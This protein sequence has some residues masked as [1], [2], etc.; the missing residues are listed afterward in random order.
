M[1]EK[2][3]GIARTI[4]MRLAD[5][6]V[7]AT[8]AL[9]GLTYQSGQPG[10][11]RA[12]LQVTGSAGVA[13]VRKAL[14]SGEGEPPLRGVRA[15]EVKLFLPDGAPL[16]LSGGG[17]APG[18][19][20]AQAQAPAAGGGEGEGAGGPRLLDLHE[21][22]GIH[23]LLNGS[24]RK[25]VPETVAAKLY[26]PAGAI[27]IEMA[28]LA[29]RLGLETTGI[30]LPIALPATGA[31]PVEIATP[32]AI[33]GENALTQQAKDE[34]GAPGG[35]AMDKLVAGQFGK[36]GA[37]ELPLLK[38]G[39]GEL[40]VVDR[41]FGV[42]PALLVR[43]D[44]EGAAAAM[45]YASGNLPYLWE[46]SKK[47]ESLE[48]MRLDLAQFFSLRSSTGQATAALFDLDEWMNKIVSG[49]KKV[50]SVEAE[51][52]VDESD[53]KL[54]DFVRDAIVAKLKTEHV[55]VKTGTLHAGSKCCDADP[56]LH[57]VS[58]TAPY[59]QGEP[60]F[61]D[62]FTI[63]WEGKRM[64]EAVR[65]AAAGISPGQPVTL[66][67]RVSEGPEERVKIKHQLEDILKQA[68]AGPADITVLCSYKSGYSW[69]VDQIEP[70]IKGKGV[71]KLK[72]EFA[73]YPDPGKQTTMRSLYRWN[74]EL[75]PVDEILA[76][77]LSLP[78]KSIE[79][80]KMDDDKGPTYRVHAYGADG[81]EILS[82][83]FTVKTVSRPYSDQFP[84]YETVTVETGWV[85]MA[86]GGTTLLDER[87]ES[88]I[89]SFW[90][91]YQK[92]TLPRIY[93][94]V[95]AQNGGKPTV[96]SQPLFDT[97]LVGYKLSEPD[98]KLGIDEE[99]ISSLEALQEDTF[100]N[101]ENFFYMLG[102]LEAGARFDYLGRILPVSYPSRDGED[103]EIHIAF[104]AKDA[105]MPK[106]RLAWKTEGDTVQHEEVRNLYEMPSAGRMRLVSARVKA[107]QEGV[108]N[109]TWR[110][111]WTSTNIT[112]TSGLC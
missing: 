3:A 104:Y 90:D 5:Q 96:D 7:E 23:G 106:V 46:P 18:N 45:K 54:K 30:T 35:T 6:K 19:A 69:I 76:R 101:T 14:T 1:G 26:V 82:K 49:G 13:A 85:K 57:N 33:A 29:G 91:H 32:V 41:A 21:L 103:G 86:T 47:F 65:K 93:K 53:P 2:L 87:V 38:P 78:L 17:P 100:F 59:K 75:F 79:F 112:T 111:P 51:V 71:S 56:D 63:P 105:G 10:I 12:V 73:P 64:M 68:G 31:S 52:D 99:Q 61:R 102:D 15:R 9:V 28:N 40:H 24:Q 42:N 48:E 50:T 66:E 98:Y 95:M 22:Y 39:E 97:L 34:L 37:P 92:E 43:G 8:V 44:D 16:L 89:E 107:G 4:N 72:I 20:V 109:L 110:C 67:V 88:D 70:M 27:G 94:I 55:D 25:L 84:E 60:T 74:Q 83:E 36:E 62:D 11:R 58:L 77:D 81:R 80:A 108:E